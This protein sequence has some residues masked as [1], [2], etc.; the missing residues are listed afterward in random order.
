MNASDHGP[1]CRK[2]LEHVFPNYGSDCTCGL[3]LM[4][5]FVE[6]HWNE[7]P[8]AVAAYVN[9]VIWW[10]AKEEGDFQ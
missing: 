4:R 3:E 10:R 9:S 7:G 6:E 2:R 5:E 1:N 8:E